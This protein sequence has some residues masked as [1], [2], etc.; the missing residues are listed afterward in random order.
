MQELKYIEVT[1]ELQ[2]NLFENQFI[3]TGRRIL[4]RGSNNII[5]KAKII[6]KIPPYEF[7]IEDTQ[8]ETCEIPIE[9][10][11]CVAVTDEEILKMRRLNIW[12]W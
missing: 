1:R 9:R 6:K 8:G 3:T 4:W 10:I 2:V 12:K 11:F 5:Y 7:L